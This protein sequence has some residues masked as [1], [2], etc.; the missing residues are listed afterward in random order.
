[1]LGRNRENRQGFIKGRHAFDGFDDKQQDT[2]HRLAHHRSQ[3]R[4]AN[5]H[6]RETEFS[7]DQQIVEHNIDAQTGKGGCHGVFYIAGTAQNGAQNKA[8]PDKRI[9]K[10]DNAEI[11]CA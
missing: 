5:A 6:L 7:E 10:A 4:A 8:C 1:M 2:V 11:L 9:G 3:R